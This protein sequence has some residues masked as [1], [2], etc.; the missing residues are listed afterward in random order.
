ML[1]NI[2]RINRIVKRYNASSI[3]ALASG[4][5]QRCGVAVIRLSGKSTVNVLLKLTNKKENIFEPRKMYLRDIWD[6]IRKE[7]IDKSLVVW[8]KG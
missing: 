6:P 7:K 1:K 4:S 3:F 8:F 5:N 2:F